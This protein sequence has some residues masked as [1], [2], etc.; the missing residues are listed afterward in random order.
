MQAVS[1]LVLLFV[2]H[3]ELAGY[4]GPDNGTASYCPCPHWYQSSNM[5][6]KLRGS[7]AGH[8]SCFRLPVFKTPTPFQRVVHAPPHLLS[9]LTRRLQRP[10]RR[11]DLLSVLTRRLQRPRRRPGRTMI[12]FNHW[13]LRFVH[14]SDMCLRPPALQFVAHVP[15]GTKAAT[16]RTNSEAATQATILL[17]AVSVQDTHTFPKSY[18]CT[19]TSSLDPHSAD[20]VFTGSTRLCLRFGRYAAFS[21]HAGVHG[22]SL[23][24]ALP[25]HPE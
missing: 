6:Y 10:R 18:P 2:V 22:R 14:T 11:P 19:S 4:R 16:C 8:K 25:G 9:V 23:K 7:D 1:E 13:R 24:Q 20:P 17:Q 3:Y 5:P 12:G 15:T 21:R